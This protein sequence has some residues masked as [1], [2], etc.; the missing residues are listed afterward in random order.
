MNND[1]AEIKTAQISVDQ[2]KERV[3]V[4]CRKRGVSMVEVSRL[5]GAEGEHQIESGERKNV[6][7]WQGLQK[8]LVDAICEL[9]TERKVEVSTTS[10]IVYLVDG[11][12]LRLPI[13]KRGTRSYKTPRWLPVVLNLAERIIGPTTK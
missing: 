3:L 9:L 8:N 4:L 13:A 10:I 11:A 2:W 5:P 12:R 1:Q 7:L 6:I